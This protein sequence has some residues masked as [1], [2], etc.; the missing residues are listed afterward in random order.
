MKFSG[1]DTQVT[2]ANRCY[3]D[4]ALFE[5]A[6]HCRDISTMTC[7]DLP[8]LTHTSECNRRADSLPAI[9]PRPH[10]VALRSVAGE[11]DARCSHE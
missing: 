7:P 10:V 2:Y 5:P 9:R 4:I 3:V 8:R 6:P 11:R 1:A